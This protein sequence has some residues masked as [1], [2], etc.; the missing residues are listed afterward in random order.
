M[1]IVSKPPDHLYRSWVASVLEIDILPQ[2]TRPCLDS[3]FRGWSDICVI[4]SGY[5]CLSGVIEMSL[6]IWYHQKW[7]LLDQKTAHRGSQRFAERNIRVSFPIIQHQLVRTKFAV[8]VNP[9]HQIHLFVVCKIRW[10]SLFYWPL[11]H[12][13]KVLSRCLEFFRSICSWRQYH[14]IYDVHKFWPVA[15]GI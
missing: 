3:I 12:D 1:K 10:R 8:A 7:F 15:H 9:F 13:I 4:D 11:P 2:P 5:C 6:N 14:V